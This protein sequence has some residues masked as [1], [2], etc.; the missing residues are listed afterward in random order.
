MESEDSGIFQI[1]LRE[2]ATGG[3]MAYDPK[4]ADRFRVALTGRP[5]VSERKMMGG[6]CF[7]VAGHMVGTVSKHKDGVHRFMFRVGPDQEDAALKLPSAQRAKMGAREMVGFVHVDADVVDDGALA[8]W[9]SMATVY[10]AGL[11]PK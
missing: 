7:K 10:V 8:D 11:P 1:T 4:L 9:V 6:L 2:T 5:D 3:N